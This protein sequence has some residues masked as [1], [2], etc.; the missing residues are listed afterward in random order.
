MEYL[1][2]YATNTL[3]W[4]GIWD[5]IDEPLLSATVSLM[6]GFGWGVQHVP[7]SPVL[8]SSV[9]EM[10]LGASELLNPDNHP[11]LHL[12]SDPLGNWI[13]YLA[14][15][16]VD[17]SDRQDE[18]DAVQLF[19]KLGLRVGNEPHYGNRLGSGDYADPQNCF[20]PEELAA[21]PNPN[22]IY[23]SAPM[24]ST[25]NARIATSCA[26]VS[27]LSYR[28][29]DVILHCMINAK[30]PMLPKMSFCSVHTHEEGDLG[31][32]VAKDF[33]FAIFCFRGTEYET[34][35]D[36]LTSVLLNPTSAFDEV[37]G[38]DVKVRDRYFKQMLLACQDSHLKN[39]TDGPGPLPH[40]SMTPSE[41]VDYLYREHPNIHIYYTGESQYVNLF[42]WLINS[43]VGQFEPFPCYICIRSF[44]RSWSCNPFWSNEEGRGSEESTGESACCYLHFWIPT[45][46]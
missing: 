22:P 10:L 40:S 26:L 7:V 12:I 28:T 30:P 29:D 46:W 9:R 23:H 39:V 5:W 8:R 42:H 33:S 43:Q 11:L 18:H 27:M 35:R 15:L 14:V 6:R 16:A 44:T 1:H 37:E 41:F 38:T 20:F 34:M 13:E 32:F 3:R 19:F 17:T 21:G 25:R 2:R 4:L 45:C 36:W 24:S 31:V